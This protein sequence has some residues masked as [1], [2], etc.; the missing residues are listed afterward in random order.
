MPLPTTRAGPPPTVPPPAEVGFGE[1]TSAAGVGATLFTGTAA[2]DLMFVWIT[3]DATQQ[4]APTGWTRLTP[5]TAA[6]ITLAGYYRVATGGIF[7]PFA[8]SAV[9]D[10]CYSW[11][12]VR[13]AS[14]V[15]SASAA[16]DTAPSVALP[17]PDA[18]VFA[19]YGRAGNKGIGLPMS[20]TQST[21]SLQIANNCHRSGSRSVAAALSGTTTASGADVA[22]TAALT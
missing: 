1:G 11:A 4:A 10:C 20:V 17:V 22:Y 14:T 18:Y 12:V 9:V 7:D 5:Q 16:S 13:N 15:T 6:G 3:A 2:G 8:V 19:G 21:S